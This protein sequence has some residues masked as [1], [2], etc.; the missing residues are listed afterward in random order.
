MVYQLNYCYVLPSL[1]KV[2]II[3]TYYYLLYSIIYYLF[4]YYYYYYYH[5]YY[6]Y[7]YYYIV[8]VRVFGKLATSP[9]IEVS[10]LRNN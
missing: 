6:Y 7:Y 8:N 10:F 5:Y 1:N 4:V 3:I 2:V 9:L